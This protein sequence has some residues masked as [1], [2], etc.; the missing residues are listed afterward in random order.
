MFDVGARQN[1]WG[2]GLWEFA[3]LR[4]GFPGVWLELCSASF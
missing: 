2:T 3:F 4:V 1:S